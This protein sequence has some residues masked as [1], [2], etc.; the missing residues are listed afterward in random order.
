[1]IYSKKT[2][3]ELDIWWDAIMRDILNELKLQEYREKDKYPGKEDDIKDP[4]W[5]IDPSGYVFEAIDSNRVEGITAY[6]L[7]GDPKADDSFVIWADAEDWGEINPDITDRDGKYG[8]DVPMGTWKVKFVG[9]EDR[10]V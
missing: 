1:M 5:K 7:I 6:A 4:D 3:T 2:G 10:C 9:N 8:W